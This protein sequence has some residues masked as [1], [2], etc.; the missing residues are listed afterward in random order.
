MLFF[1]RI[2]L[3]FFHTFL[4]LQCVIAV[5]GLGG[6]GNPNVGKFKAPDSNNRVG[7]QL[8]QMLAEAPAE[9]TVPRKPTAET[10]LRKRLVFMAHHQVPGP[11]SELHL[12]KI[13]M[14]G[15]M[16]MVYSVKQY[17]INTVDLPG[18]LTLFHFGNEI[19]MASSQKGG[20][21]LSWTRNNA[22][23]AL[24]EQ[25]ISAPKSH[26]AKCGEMSAAQIF[27][28]L[29]SDGSITAAQ[30]TTV[31]I[32][33]KKNNPLAVEKISLKVWPPCN[34]DEVSLIPFFSPL[35]KLLLTQIIR[36]AVVV[37]N[38]LD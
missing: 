24:V 36:R 25:C 2:L 14:D 10:N 35:A 34:L 27:Q 29:H 26:D 12:I 15:Y 3:L 13:A 8:D 1:Y 30:I 20:T 28:H 11:I 18:V 4:W 38:L 31:T 17:R 5:G 19:I 23:S 33:A 6:K 21:A 16:D 7:V 9:A 32:M 22:V 37:T